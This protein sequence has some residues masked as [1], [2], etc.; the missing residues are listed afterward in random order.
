MYLYTAMV[1]YGI[2]TLKPKPEQQKETYKILTEKF[3]KLPARTI[4]IA[5]HSDIA[6]I[7]NSY[8]GLEAKNYP[9]T[10]RFD[11]D[12]SEFFIDEIN[13]KIKLKIAI[14]RPEKGT[15][16]WITTTLMPKRNLKYKYY[17]HLFQSRKGMKLPFQ[18]KM[19]N[20]QIYAKI[21]V[22]RQTLLADNTKPTVYVGIDLRAHWLGKIK[23]G[24]PMAVS[25]I[26]DEGAFA[27]QPVL[28]HEWSEIPTLIRRYQKDKQKFKKIIQNQIG[29]IIKQLIEYTKE[30][31]PVY[32]I[33]NLTNL[34]KIEGPYSKIFYRKFR[35]MLET[36]SLNIVTVNPAYTSTTCSRC[37]E[38]G[39]TEKRTF[40]CQKCYPKGFNK[41]INA[42]INIAKKQ[43]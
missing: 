33:E 6:G 43:E 34:N 27:R 29:L 1:K 32:K 37:G 36:K 31:S 26:T 39:K 5:V 13:Q 35:S 22:E 28:M 12:N 16:Y 20:G 42:S 40:Y 2:K 11:K 7:I 14:D 10:M 18:L 23:H 8:N 25:F 3:E 38:K 21:T 24:N 19:R 17:R 41:F 15:L 30:Y 9:L 4:T